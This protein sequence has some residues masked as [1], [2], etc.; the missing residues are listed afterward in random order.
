MMRI[1][2]AQPKLCSLSLHDALPM[3]GIG[4]PVVSLGVPVAVPTFEYWPVIAVPLAAKTQGS[5]DRT[6]A[7]LLPSPEVWS[8]LL[9]AMPPVTA[10]AESGTVPVV[11]APVGHVEGRP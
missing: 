8:R 3:S 6:T 2:V 4:V 11:V 7:S 1:V 5:L 9:P 10:T